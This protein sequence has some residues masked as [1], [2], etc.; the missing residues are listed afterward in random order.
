MNDD[1]DDKITFRNAMKDVRRLDNDHHNRAEPPVSK[2][3]ARPIQ[4]LKDHQQVLQDMMSDPVDE[5][6]IVTG[7]ELFFSR[8]GIQNKVIRQLKRG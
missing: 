8:S 1:N 7:D 3:P 4:R 6:D 5:A 2:P